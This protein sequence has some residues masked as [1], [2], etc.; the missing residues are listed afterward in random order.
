MDVRRKPQL[1]LLLSSFLLLLP[2][3]LLLQ[4]SPTQKTNENLLV[5]VRKG[6]PWVPWEDI[7]QVMLLL[8]LLS[9]PAVSP[10]FHTPA[11]SPIPHT[12]A[13]SPIPHT[14]DISPIPH[15]PA[16]SHAPFTPEYFVSPST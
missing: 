6:K 14:P 4:V 16:I 8:L 2:L 9:T 1:L 11:V 3:N 15:T 13:V 10:I 5:P 7:W 12:P